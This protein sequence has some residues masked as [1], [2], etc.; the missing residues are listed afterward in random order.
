MVISDNGKILIHD[1][2]LFMSLSLRKRFPRMFKVGTALLVGET[3]T[4]FKGLI[5]LYLDIA[6]V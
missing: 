4:S 2:T 1:L 5:E 3:W 6:V